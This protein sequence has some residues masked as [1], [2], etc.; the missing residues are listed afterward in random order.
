[1]LKIP[2]AIKIMPIIL[3]AFTCSS[4]KMIEN[5]VIKI[6]ENTVKGYA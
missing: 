1:M 4:K 6:R 2:M 5:R 3:W